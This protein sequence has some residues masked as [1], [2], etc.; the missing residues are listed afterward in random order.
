MDVFTIIYTVLGGLGIFFYGMRG[1]S[2]A[3]QA[4][5]GDTV[6]TI[7]NSLTT[8]RFFAVLVGLGVTTIVQSSSITTVMVVGLVNAGLMQLSQ[9][10]GV[11]FGANIGTTITGWIISIK[12]GK[13]GLLLIGAGIFPAL[14][15][16]SEKFKQFGKV[17]FSVGLIFFGLKIMS[18]AFKP[19]RSMPEFLEMISYFSAQNYGSYLASVLVGCL[20]TLIIQS[21][22]AMLGI[23]I[24]LATAGV[25]NFHTAAAL[26][27]GE[28]IGTTITALLASVGGNINAKRASRGHAIFNLMGVVCILSIFPYFVELVEWIVPGAANFV[29]EDGDKPNI[30]VHIATGHTLFNVT[31]TLLF[32]PFLNHLVRFIVKITPDREAKEQFHLVML[33][34]ISTHSPSA[35]LL[36]VENEVLKMHQI[37]G[38]MFSNTREYLSHSSH[39]S[40]L[41]AKIQDHEKIT[42]NI[43]KEITL[44]VC[45]IMEREL[46]FDQ[47]AK[48]QNMVRLADELESVADYLHLTVILKKR[49]PKSSK[50]PQWADEEYF[51]LFDRIEEF[52]SGVGS[53]LVNAADHDQSVYDRLADE[54]WQLSED[55]RSRYVEK[56]SAGEYDP[57]TTLTFSDMVVALRKVRSHIHNISQA[58]ARTPS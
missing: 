54:L 43:Q 19:L 27:L 10:V 20:L 8:N 53:G 3:L 15:A 23:T 56:A 30:A 57:L 58:I 9:A 5:A 49:W 26:V 52:F 51:V 18:G 32:L 17:L 35:A 41:A 11:I 55:S 46:T 40:E 38:K 7:I 50:I 22:S 44:F 42:D 48:A 13:Y 12:V 4:Y 29:N 39:S 28:N 25:I 21:S 2:D 37:V 33:G 6:R 36:Q 14:F 45:K 16:K 24:A 1:M 34:D 47:S 31:A